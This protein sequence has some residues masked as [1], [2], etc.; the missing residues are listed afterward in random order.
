MLSLAFFTMTHSATHFWRPLS[1]FFLNDVC[2]GTHHT[3]VHITA[4][5]WEWKRDLVVFTLQK[6]FLEVF[7]KH[8]WILDCYLYNAMLRAPS[9]MY[10]ASHHTSR[11]AGFVLGLTHHEPLGSSLS[12]SRHVVGWWRRW[13]QR[14]FSDKPEEA[15][16]QKRWM[17]KR[18]KR[19]CLACWKRPW[20]AFWL[21]GAAL[22]LNIISNG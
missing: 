5:T 21:K 16:E 7:D 9:P 3:A 17:K 2:T 12:H 1:Y 4:C 15:P 20:I 8:A 6:A 11:S 14:R 18:A 13:G 22:A 19:K 10:Q